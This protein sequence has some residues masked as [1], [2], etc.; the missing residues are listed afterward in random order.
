MSLHRALVMCLT[1]SIAVGCRPP[2]SRHG[3]GVP[4]RDRVGALQ[5]PAQLTVPIVGEVRGKVEYAYRHYPD[6]EV[7]RVSYASALWGGCSATMIG[8]RFVLTAAHCGPPEAAA[9]QKGTLTFTTYRSDETSLSSESYTC[10]RLIHGWP[11]HDLAL[12]YCDVGAD[13]LGPGDK[14]GY[15]DVDTRPP[16]VGDA[17]YSIWWNTVTNGP[18]PGRMLPLYS[19]GKVT[20]ITATIWGGLLGGGPAGTPVG[21]GMDLW[22]Q[23]GAS[24][25]SHI[26]LNTHR[27]LVG[28]TSTGS[29][30]APGR[31][32]FSMGTYFDAELLPTGD[33]PNGVG[34]LQNV[35]AGNF[36]PGPYDVGDF[37]GLVDKDRNSIFDVQEVIELDIGES[38]RTAY[39]LGFDNRRR[40]RLWETGVSAVVHFSIDQATKSLQFGVH[41]PELVLWHRHLNLKPDTN[42][43]VGVK[44]RTT[45]AAD[46]AALSIGFERPGQATWSSAR[47]RTTPGAEVLRTALIR[48]DGNPDSQL[49]LR[50]TAAFSGAVSEIQLIEDGATSTFELADDRQGWT[51]LLGG[52]SGP[53]PANFLPRGS[54]ATSTKTDFALAVRALLGTV[55]PV[56][57]EK[58]L[59]LPN[60]GQR[61]CFMVKALAETNVAG[62]VQV[63]SGGSQVL[64]K[65][66]PL[67]T[68]WQWHCFD[69]IQTPFTNT[70]LTFGGNDGSPSYLVDQVGLYL[71]PNVIVGPAG[72][73]DPKR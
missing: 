62:A 36:P 31:Q 64:N 19:A 6:P 59:F 28:P 48:T 67:T 45:S 71:D 57:T 37:V 46:A 4:A 10:R 63:H 23:P 49:A 20:S 43:R 17:V 56:R 14:Y 30:D 41:G 72:E 55:N 66:F 8:P 18:N 13:G 38:R 47:L 25:S 58:L 52:S 26:D 24:G 22:T 35:T 29:V 60:R 27:I 16:A 5:F 34:N 73:L 61:L 70:T 7:A 44:V 12:L 53:G 3:S 2:A 54:G 39:W 15:L 68:S 50:T 69:R 11:R 32:A 33:Y 51:T 65:S 9:T 1:F 42:Y 21:I 40:N